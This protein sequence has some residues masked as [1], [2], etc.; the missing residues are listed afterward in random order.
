MP[1][2]VHT[3]VQWQAGAGTPVKGSVETNGSIS[4]SQN[5]NTATFTWTGTVTCVN[6]PHNSKNVWRC[7]D[8]ACWMAGKE[9]WHGTAFHGDVY[10]QS[11]PFG[12][13]HSTSNML[14][15]FRLDTGRNEGPN[16]MALWGSTGGMLIPTEDGDVSI[17]KNFSYTYTLTLT[18]DP[19]QVVLSYNSSG[20][21]STYDHT[22][23]LYQEFVWVRDFINAGEIAFDYR[24]GERLTG[25]S[26]KS[27][28][29]DGGVCERNASWYEMRTRDGDKGGTGQPPE[30]MNGGWK[31]QKK[32]GAE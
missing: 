26:W 21:T 13:G 14:M 19:D 9:D 31:N 32:I 28:N 2:P 17:T 24:P 6:H 11:L 1:V 4:V 25:G 20:A 7:S 10:K 27:L 3:Y 23:H 30:R 22:W 8:F 18:E 12:G 29:R 16:S 5:G 15:E